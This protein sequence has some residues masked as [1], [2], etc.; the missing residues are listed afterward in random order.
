MNFLILSGNVKEDGLCHSITESV[1]AGAQEGGATVVTRTLSGLS[2]CR[3]C[4]EGWG[5][6]RAEHRCAFGEEDDFSAIQEEVK[7]ADALCLI[8]PVYWGEPAETLK[9]VL[10]KLRRCEFGQAGALSGKQVLL[11]ASAGGSGNGVL[12]CLE[13]LDRFCRHTGGLIFDYIA[14]NRWNQDYKKKAAYAAA[15][16]IALDHQE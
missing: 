5:I 8:T 12:T 16:A 7:R 11:V 15:T 10:D 4:G 2:Q 14:V 3:V 9:G 6:C 1:V 13:Q